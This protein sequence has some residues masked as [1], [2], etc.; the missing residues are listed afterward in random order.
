M[1]DVAL[2]ELEE[3]ID[4]ADASI[5]DSYVVSV[6]A[7]WEWGK[8]VLAE[9]GDAGRLRNGRMTELVALS[10]RSRSELSYRIQLAERYVSEAELSTVVDGCESWTQVRRTLVGARPDEGDEEPAQ[11]PSRLRPVFLAETRIHDLLAGLASV[12]V[13]D[14]TAHELDQAI[15]SIDQIIDN[16]REVRGIYGG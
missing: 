15:A 9:R 7:R 10:G 14:F 5:R 8:H 11:E 16:A 4:Q 1:S 6:F 2:L 12:N 3:T 13:R